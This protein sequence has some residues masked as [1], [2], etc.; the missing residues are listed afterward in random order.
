M[1]YSCPVLSILL[2]LSLSSNLPDINQTSILVSLS[3]VWQWMD[4]N[5]SDI[6]T[7][8]EA[9]HFYMRL[10][11]TWASFSFSLIFLLLVNF[12]FISAFIFLFSSMLHSGITLDCP[13]PILRTSLCLLC[14]MWTDSL[15]SLRC[16]IGKIFLIWSY[17]I[18]FNCVHFFGE[19]HNV[20]IFSQ[21]FYRQETVYS[22]GIYNTSLGSCLQF[23]LLDKLYFWH[24]Y[25]SW[26]F[27]F[28]G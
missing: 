17:V 16:W 13:R 23:H 8:T 21:A 10:T 1:G 20:A 4:V 6:S 22:F 3:T 11:N 7:R 5:Q 25:P 26:P 9:I 19:E 27:F 14:W 24:F 12:F 2:D 15:Q 28:F 18:P